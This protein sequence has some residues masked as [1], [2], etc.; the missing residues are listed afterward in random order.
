MKF[1][2][3][4][5]EAFVAAAR[6]GSFTRAASALRISQ[7][8]FTVHIRQLEDALGVR[9]LDRNTRPMELTPLGRAL[10]GPLERALRDIDSTF[11]NIEELT[12]KTHGLVAVAAI[13]SLAVSML[14][15]VIA[16]FK[17]THPGISV[18]PKDV[19]GRRFAFMVKSGE[20]DFG[21]GSIPASEPD[22]DFMPLFTDRIGAIFV[23]GGPLERKKSVT[24]AELASYPLILM[25]REFSVR[26]V[27]E[28][29]LS[30][31]ETFSG[32]E[33]ETTYISTTLAMVR[34][35]LGVAIVPE[36]VFQ[37]EDRR[38]LNWIP[39]EKPST[40]RSIGIVRKRGRTLSPAAEA[41]VEAIRAACG[42]AS[43]RKK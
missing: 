7:P 39:I 12:N 35:G 13:P 40:D 6:Y 1:E 22:L 26:E 20:V 11:L 5:L 16:G 42:K 30:R 17:I 4:N 15:G 33:Y 43:K 8:T 31:I 2:L 23:R 34:V 14:A 37:M 9:L 3:K 28:D 25:D 21:F 27:I 19:V 29:A 18:Q 38:K 41:L 10:V 32:P 24:L 36:T